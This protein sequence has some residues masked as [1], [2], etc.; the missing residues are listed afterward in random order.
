MLL[1][2]YALPNKG[3]LSSKS[4]D[5]WRLWITMDGDGNIRKK[6]FTELSSNWSNETAEAFIADFF[7]AGF[8][9]SGALV[10]RRTYAFLAEVAKETKKK[11]PEGMSQF[12]VLL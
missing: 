6:L 5:A 3:D 12:V 1:I 8:G 11:P 10:P 4:I 7:E 2:I 9:K